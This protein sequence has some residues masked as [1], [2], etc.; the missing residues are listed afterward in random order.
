M[1]FISNSGEL[2]A[3]EAVLNDLPLRVGLFTNPMSPGAGTVYPN[4]TELPQGANYS[5]ATKNL[6]NIVQEAGLTPGTWFVAPD[7]TGKEAAQYCDAAGNAAA[8]YLQ[9]SFNA[10]DVASAPTVYGAFGWTL[11]V[12][13]TS[14]NNQINPGDLI[15]VGTAN[16]IVASVKVMSGS[17]AG[18]NAV[19]ELIIK[20]QNGTFANNTAITVG[21]VTKATTNT[22]TAYGGDSIKQLVFVEVFA[23]PIP[24]T[25]AGQI[26]QYT[27]TLT[28]G[29]G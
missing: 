2:K 22:G 4:L 14:G 29:T 16:A 5:Y 23:S 20:T 10:N 6:G 3:L 12:P 11:I 18:N 21:G 1:I 9:W 17:W 8:P 19:G 15:T 26:I 28:M 25:L 24:L 13:F 27:L 7:S